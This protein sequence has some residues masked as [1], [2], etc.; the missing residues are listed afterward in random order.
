[1]G[2]EDNRQA[3]II[4]LS[5]CGRRAQLRLRR[6]TRAGLPPVVKRASM[7]G[8]KFKNEPTALDVSLQEPP[9]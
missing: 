4:R 5:M 9:L 8:E 1:M 2:P 3:L 7:G 6:T